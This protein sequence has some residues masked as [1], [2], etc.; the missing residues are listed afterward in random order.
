MEDEDD[1]GDL[2]GGVVGAVD[3]P[4]AAAE[5]VP[6]QGEGKAAEV[7]GVKKMEEIQGGKTGGGEEAGGTT[8]AEEG[9]DLYGGN[10]RTSSKRV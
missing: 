1:F 8:G 7:E 10:V 2:Y 5:V 6:G 3:A 9:E 4:A